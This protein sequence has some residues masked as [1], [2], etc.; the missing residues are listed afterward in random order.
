MA[1]TFDALQGLLKGEEVR[2]FV[3]PSR[4]AVLFGMKGRNGRYQIVVSLDNDGRFLKLRT[5]E[6]LY[7]PADHPHRAT[8][9][10]AVAHATYSF[11]FV[12]FGWDPRDGEIN[13][14]GDVWIADGT[15]TPG[16]F[17]QILM[18]FIYGIDRFYP[19]FKEA[20]EKGE[21]PGLPAP[22][23]KPEDTAET[24]GAEIREI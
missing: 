10:S 8:V 12:K 19:R 20:L 17:E 23:E 4:E 24:E 18:N 7:C 15:L 22:E 14:S 13:G 2:F 16:Q 9:L 11:R 6:Y 5:L 1:L 21:D 3:D